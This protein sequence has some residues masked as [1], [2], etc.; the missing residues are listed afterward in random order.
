MKKTAVM[1]CLLAVAWAGQ[2]AAQGTSGY[3]PKRINRAIELLEQGQPIYYTGGRGGF[4]EGMKSAQTWAD[5]INYEL[6]HG[7]FDMTMLRQ[8]MQGLV[9]G[10][11]T[12]SGHR[13]PAVIVT[14][15]V[16]GLDE[17]TVR[18]NSWVVQ[19]VLATGVHGILL[20]HARTAGAARAMVEATRYTFSSKVPGLG[21]GLRGS[22]SQGFASQIWGIPGDEYIQR[23]DVWPLNPK[24]E[25]LLG[26]K[27]EDR[28]ALQNAEESTR[29]PGIA[30]A[31]WGPGDMSW[32]LGLVGARE[33]AAGMPPEM[34][35]ARA[36]VLA[37]CKAAKIAFLNS[38][39]E[40]TVEAM[41]KEGVMI[42]SGN[43]A[44]AARG[45][46]FTK[47]AMPW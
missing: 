19:Q 8:F 37:A 7:A 13:T 39:S 33:R 36:R 9:K 45:R 5:Y 23:A 44:A 21:E 22:G 35:Q 26:L 2:L 20:C 14:I 1:V 16:T 30:F 4:E 40:S 41:I 32:S 10:G 31:E 28:Q 6:E 47:R 38:V 43:E 24:G 42:G 18:V 17:L 46:K 29:V 3:K 15:P 27:I 12:K 34:T 11:P 25:I